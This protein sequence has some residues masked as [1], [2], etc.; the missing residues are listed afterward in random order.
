MAF[1]RNAA[2]AFSRRRASVARSM[3]IRSPG[4]AMHAASSSARCHFSRSEG[5]T[6]LPPP[7]SAWS[8]GSSR[9]TSTISVCRK[10]RRVCLVGLA[11]Y[12]RS[13]GSDGGIGLP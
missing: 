13:H 12:T 1:V 7:S 5:L 8:I 3:A 2:A 9:S 10:C 6:A 11:A 4:R